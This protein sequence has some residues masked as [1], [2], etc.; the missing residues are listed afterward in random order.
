L[1]VQVRYDLSTTIASMLAAIAT[2]S[3]ALYIVTQA[4]ALRRGLPSAV[5]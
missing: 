5:P 3:F 1:P 2:S 4:G